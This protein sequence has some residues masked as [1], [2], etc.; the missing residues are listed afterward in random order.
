MMMLSPASNELPGPSPNVLKKAVPISGAQLAI[1]DRNR[2]FEAST[3][4]SHRL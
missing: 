4:A 2:S 3:E 1:L